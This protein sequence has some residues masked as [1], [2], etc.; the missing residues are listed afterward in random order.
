MTY[1]LSL[2]LWGQLVPRAAVQAKASPE[3][4]TARKV[5][6]KSQM[7]AP[8]VTGRSCTPQGGGE[9]AKLSSNHRHYASRV[10]E[11][12][13][14]SEKEHRVQS[15]PAQVEKALCITEKPLKCCFRA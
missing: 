7:R 5:D 6:N 2:G 11:N 14:A 4:T 9:M 1:I 10:Q 3:F 13:K 12:Q 15:L 8:Q